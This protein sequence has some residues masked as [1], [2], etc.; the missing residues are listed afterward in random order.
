MKFCKLTSLADLI[1]AEPGV[2]LQI[3]R[4]S[5]RHFYKI[6]R[7]YLISPIIKNVR[8]PLKH[9]SIHVHNRGAAYIYAAPL[10]EER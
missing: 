7:Q 8:N 1:E 4:S 9:E 3:L 2:N 5:E 10:L 6:V